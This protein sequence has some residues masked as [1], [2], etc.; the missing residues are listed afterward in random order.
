MTGQ[1]RLSLSSLFRFI[2]L[3]F[4]LFLS[5]SRERRLSTEHDSREEKRTGRRRSNGKTSRQKETRASRCSWSTTTY[6]SVAFCG[7]AARRCIRRRAHYKTANRLHRQTCCMS[8]PKRIP[9]VGTRPT[10][11]GFL[12]SY[13]KP[14]VFAF[15]YFA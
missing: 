8:K 2:C 12:A 10:N 9:S 1:S 11:Q 3:S 14:I 6:L 15:Q 4:V 13:G 5:L 7:H